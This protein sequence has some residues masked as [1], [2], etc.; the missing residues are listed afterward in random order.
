[1]RITYRQRLLIALLNIDTDLLDNLKSRSFSQVSSI[2]IDT[3][4]LS[5]YIP[6]LQKRL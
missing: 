2:N 4:I 5:K 3:K 6:S 1:M